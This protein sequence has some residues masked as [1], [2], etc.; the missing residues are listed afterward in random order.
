MIVALL[1]ACAQPVD[2][3]FVVYDPARDC[4]TTEVHTVDA[5]MWP[6]VDDLDA[7][8]MNGPSAFATADGTCAYVDALV[9]RRQGNGLISPE[10][11]PWITGCAQGDIDCCAW[12]TWA[13]A[14]CCP[15]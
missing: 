12:W 5:R 11:D 4:V 13:D 15:N 2:R 7:A 9:D 6:A 10:D 1:L 8:R 3:A 14:P